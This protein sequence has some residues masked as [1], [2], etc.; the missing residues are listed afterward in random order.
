MPS[1]VIYLYI[2][3]GP[4]QSMLA[5]LEVGKKGGHSLEAKQEVEL[6]IVY[7]LGRNPFR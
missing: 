1:H 6:S 2:V 3:L 4:L 7:V 5:S